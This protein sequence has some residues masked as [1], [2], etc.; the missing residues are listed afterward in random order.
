MYDAA[1][2][3]YGFVLSMTH[4]VGSAACNMV[5][6]AVYSVWKPWPETRYWAWRRLDPE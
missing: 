3:V 1:Y 5:C 2:N 4:V 6:D